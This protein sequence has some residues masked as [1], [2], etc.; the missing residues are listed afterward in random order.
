MVGDHTGWPFTTSASPALC[1]N[2]SLAALGTEGSTANRLPTDTSHPAW[3]QSRAAPVTT[4]KKHDNQQLKVLH[5]NAKN[6]R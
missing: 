1:S 5:T 4:P 6:P 3:K 2:W